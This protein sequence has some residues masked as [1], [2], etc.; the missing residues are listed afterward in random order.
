MAQERRRSPRYPFFASAELIEDKS[1]VRITTRLSELGL[2][3]CYLDMMNPF[4]TGTS[5][6]IKI[7]EGQVT[8]EAHATVVY[9]Q[10]NMGM[11]VAFRDVEERYLKLLQ[12]WMT[13][14]QNR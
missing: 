6:L 11:G 5:V 12:K 2:Y 3:G 9:S 10:V 4:P 13:D 14:A 8:F 1:D 7:T